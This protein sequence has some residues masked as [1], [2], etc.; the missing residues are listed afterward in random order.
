MENL[1]WDVQAKVCR[2]RVGINK[3]KFKHRF[4]KKNSKKCILLFDR[5]YVDCPRFSRIRGKGWKRGEEVAK[6]MKY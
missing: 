6:N 1:R 5:K 4:F 2:R 3:E